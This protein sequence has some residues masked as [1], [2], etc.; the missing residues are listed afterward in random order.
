MKATQ[1]LIKRIQFREFIVIISLCFTYF[2]FGPL[3]MLLSNRSSDWFGP[4][5]LLVLTFPAFIVLCFVLLFVFSIVKDKARE[6]LLLLLFAVLV[7]LYLQGNLPIFD[8]G[9]LNGTEIDWEAVQSF[10]PFL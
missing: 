1:T 7:A 10:G 3:D 5:Q 2:V 8:Y 6:L 9:T 4:K